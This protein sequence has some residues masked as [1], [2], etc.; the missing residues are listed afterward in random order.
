VK[1]WLT[2][3]VLIALVAA[4]AIHVARTEEVLVS[5]RRLSIGILILTSLIQ[6]TSQLFL[7]GALLLPLQSCVERLGF[8]ELYVVRTGGFVVGQLV[9]VAGGLAVRLAYLKNRGLT[10]LDFTWATLLSNVVALLSAA[11]V[12]LLAT[13]VLW[14][15]IDRPPVAVLGVSLG[16][17]AMAIAALAVFELLPRLT[18]LPRFQR[19]RWLSEMKSLRTSGPMAISVF[20]LSIARHLLNF[21]TFGLLTQSLSGRPGDFLT[22]GLMYALTSPIRMVNITPGNLGVTEWVVALVGKVVAVDVTNGLLVALAFRGVAL[23]GQGLGML[24]GSAW[25]AA[26]KKV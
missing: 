16:V 8:W 2:L 15:L 25:L 6:F 4:M 14:A 11:V 1:R 9:P 24:I 12:A 7:N 10:Y 13:A 5:V 3:A 26:R 20:G 22:G 23:V 18:R 21:T 19:W 17:L